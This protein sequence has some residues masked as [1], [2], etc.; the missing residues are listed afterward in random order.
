MVLTDIYLLYITSKWGPQYEEDRKYI[1][2]R[3]HHVTDHRID[4]MSDAPHRRI[5]RSAISQQQISEE[6]P[7]HSLGTTL[8][9]VTSIMQ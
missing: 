7:S 8:R 9:I 4:R 6:I 3:Y 2:D 5:E 1:P